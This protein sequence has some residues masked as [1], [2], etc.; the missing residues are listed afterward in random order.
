MTKICVVRFQ[1]RLCEGSRFLEVGPAKW[2]GSCGRR[3][4]QVCRN[5][6]I[7]RRHRSAE[8]GKAECWGVEDSPNARCLNVL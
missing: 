4:L 6:N 3:L 7:T 5:L 2:L 1:Q 8:A